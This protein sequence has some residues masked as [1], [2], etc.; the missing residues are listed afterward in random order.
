MNTEPTVPQPASEA[1]SPERVRAL[2]SLAALDLG[3]DLEMQGLVCDPDDPDCVVDG[4][5]AGGALPLSSA[6][7]H[8]GA[9]RSE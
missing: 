3:D 5:S 2:Q 1:P 7:A 8:E 9:T 6:A 4:A